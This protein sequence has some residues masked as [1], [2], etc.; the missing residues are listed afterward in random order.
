L[1]TAPAARTTI[2]S[3]QIWS[4]NPS[5]KLDYS[6]IE[7]LSAQELERLREEAEQARITARKLRLN[8]VGA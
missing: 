6:N 1:E 2:Q 4:E 7:K 5:W 3:P 8:S